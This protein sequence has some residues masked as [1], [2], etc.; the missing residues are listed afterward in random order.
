M[1]NKVLPINNVIPKVKTKYHECNTCEHE[2]YN[3]RKKYKSPQKLIL[4]DIT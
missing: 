4:Q 2:S 1:A 3:Y